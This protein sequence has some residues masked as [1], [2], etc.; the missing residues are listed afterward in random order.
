MGFFQD[1]RAAIEQRLAN[2]WSSTDIAWDNIDYQPTSETAFIRCL[3]EEVDSRQVSSQTTPCHRVVG[4]IH[5]M[6]MVPTNTG[7]NTARGYADDIAA[8]FR[9]AN[10]SDIQCTS[11]RIERVGDIGEWFQYS[12]LIP[13]WADKALANA[14]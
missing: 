10:F 5:I 3:V 11:P 9:N 14:T 13:F 6:I 8:I 4:Y 1:I 2:N 7:T 12:V